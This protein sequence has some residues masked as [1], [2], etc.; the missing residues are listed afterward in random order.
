MQFI[1]TW[2]GWNAMDFLLTLFQLFP[3]AQETLAVLLP[4]CYTFPEIF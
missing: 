3:T 2:I 1:I 4:V